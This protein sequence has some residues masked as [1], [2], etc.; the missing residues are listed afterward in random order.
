MVGADSHKVIG[1][2][3][4]ASS[5][6]TVGTILLA[7]QQCSSVRLRAL[8]QDRHSEHGLLY[9]TA[10]PDGSYQQEGRQPGLDTELSAWEL[11]C[12]ALPT[13]V[14]AGQEVFCFARG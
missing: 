8:V 9:P 12:H 3:A 13:T 14:F 5:S 7:V 10:V 2:L 6:R 11:A 1:L 4:L